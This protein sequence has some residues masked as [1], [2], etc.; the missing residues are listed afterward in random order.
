[1]YIV[2][3]DVGGTL[4]DGIFNGAGEP[5]LV[6]VDT[7]PHDLTVCFFDCLQ[8]GA[9]QLGF[10]SLATF[11]DEVELI[12]WSTTITSNVL[13]ERRGPKIGLIVSRGHERD[14]YAG[15]ASR[16]I[17]YVVQAPNIIGVEADAARE[18][19]LAA[20]RGLLE[21]GVR[22]ICVS[23][24]GAFQRPEH[25]HLIREFIEEQY[26]DHYLGAVPVL[27][28]SEMQ[29]SADDMTRTHCAL[30]NAYTHSSLASTLF[31][32][33]DRLRYDEFYNG[34]FLIN[35]INGGVAT[36]AKTRAIDTMESGPVLGLY[37]S[38]YFAQVYGA[39]RVVALD[40]GGTTAKVGLIVNGE[41]YP[42]KHNDLFGIPVEISLPYLRSIALGGGS[43]V[44]VVSGEIGLGPESMGSYPGP[45]C[46]GLGTTEATLTDA[47]V[48]AGIIDPDFFL[49]GEK[50]LH[51]DRA[52]AAVSNGPAA[53]LAV[54]TEA[55]VS[56][57][58]DLAFKMV[59]DKI[60]E[61]IAS[62]GEEPS[63]FSL[64]AYGGNGGLFA[65]SVAERLG[66][67]DVFMFTT[68]PVFSAFGSSMSDLSHVYEHAYRLRLA[69]DFDMRALCQQ[70]AEMKALALLDI[71]GEGF[72]GRDTSLSVELDLVSGERRESVR[73]GYD[74]IE[75]MNSCEELRKR[76]AGEG[77]ADPADL[78]TELLRLTAKEEMAKPRVEKRRSDA[79]D[80]EPVGS[81]PVFLT[82][83]GEEARIYRMNALQPGQTFS[84]CAII[85]TSKT[86]YMVPGGWQMSIDGHGNG[87]AAERRRT[88]AITL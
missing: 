11:L 37:A 74:E 68:G 75:R 54:S 84:A 13:A 14:L 3:I 87:R 10:T 18:E 69:E 65:C 76:L 73:L 35:H 2:D 31:N 36:I 26:P 59:A 4:T 28:G 67:T 70:L 57:I 38:R 23:L 43:L 16:A 63:R 51:R 88:P 58:L 85:E 5:L 7:T 50:K 46:Y 19:I 80:C 45:A 33:E 8:A 52:L 79:A 60:S 21:N 27:L 77:I 66:I 42:S 34:A 39:D 15:D 44:K 48:A 1:M 22:R 83:G 81:R 49:G 82:A 25:E 32:A 86:T 41:P 72:S 40:V 9:E 56:A 17:D 53:S 30:I 20:V 64:F 12:R 62:V 47:F 71:Q 78:E 24:A 6:K 29:R 61:A 55:A